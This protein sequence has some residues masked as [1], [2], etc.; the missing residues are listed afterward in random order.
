MRLPG[1]RLTIRRLM[2]AVATTAL[3]IASFLWVG[4]S[5]DR[6]A[7]LDAAAYHAGREREERD[8]VSV[9]AEA[10]EA[11]GPSD[12]PL[13]PIIERGARERAVYHAELARKYRDAAARPWEPVGPDPAPPDV[14]PGPLPL[15]TDDVKLFEVAPLPDAEGPGDHPRE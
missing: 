7:R 11:G 2:A 12:G 1:F 3:A 13:M 5:R 4:W 10:R 6:A 9:I 15:V 8:Q 14:L